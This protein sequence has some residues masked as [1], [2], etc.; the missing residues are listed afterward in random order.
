MEKMKFRLG[1]C[2]CAQ[3]MNTYRAVTM[4]S[5]AENVPSGRGALPD[6]GRCW[7]NRY[8][9]QVLMM[10]VALTFSAAALF[11]LFDTN[12]DIHRKAL[13]IG[14]SV[15]IATILVTL[16]H[17]WKRY[18][19]IDAGEFRRIYETNRQ[20]TLRYIG[21]LVVSIAV[22]GSMAWWAMN[23]NFGFILAGFV[24][25]CMVVWASYLT[26]VVWERLRHKIVMS[27]KKSMYTVDATA[28]RTLR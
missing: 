20:R 7:Q 10:A 25:A 3:A 19:G 18:D 6:T 8:R 22:I 27:E 26:V 23:G 2:P 14:I 1:W 13:V 5:T 28:G 16:W 11:L 15:G 12:P 4:E 9:N 24:G 17:S 21:I